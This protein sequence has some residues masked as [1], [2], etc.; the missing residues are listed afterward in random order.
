MTFD[1]TCERGGVQRAPQETEKIPPAFG[2][3]SSR[4]GD[5]AAWRP[6]LPLAA[7]PGRAASPLL[8]A[9]LTRGLAP[10]AFSTSPLP[11][12]KAL[13]TPTYVCR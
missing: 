5:W 12:T 2:F 6:G 1:G 10:G 8:G 4:S 3:W 11:N 13:C 7:S 9:G